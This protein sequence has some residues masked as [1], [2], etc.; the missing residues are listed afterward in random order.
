MLSNQIKGNINV[1]M[2]LETEI[3]DSFPNGIF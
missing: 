2:V 1:L 3:D